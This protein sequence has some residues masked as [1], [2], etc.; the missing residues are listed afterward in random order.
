MGRIVSA[1][2]QNVN[3]IDWNS[4]TDTPTV[5]G[6]GVPSTNQRH[7]PRTLCMHHEPVSVSLLGFVCSLP[8]PAAEECK[9]SE[10]YVEDMAK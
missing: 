2:C 4:G 3:E 9:A 1:K 10:R 5:P 8:H 7:Q 6:V